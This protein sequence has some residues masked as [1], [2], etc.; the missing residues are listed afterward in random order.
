M[1]KKNFFEG[2]K[3][4]KPVVETLKE[5]NHEVVINSMSFTDSF[6]L[7]NGELKEGIAD[8]VDSKEMWS[9]STP[10]LAVV[11]VSAIG[12]GVMTY[13]FNALGYKH[14]DDFTEEE[15]NDEKYTVIGDYVCIEDKD[16]N[17]V[18][19]KDDNRTK[20][21]QRILNQFLDATGAE[22]GA[23]LV[24][25]IENC[26][27]EKHRLAVTVVKGEYE[28]KETYDISKFAKVGEV[29]PAKEGVGSEDF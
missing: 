23:E 13:R 21:A 19:I 11:L 6:H 25:I 8:K 10:Q 17:L 26:I 14:V 18:R 16:N 15:L 7:L 22:E 2:F 27:A 29:V 24:P 3:F 28:D 20:K 9:D 1:K 4:E 12:D 5:G